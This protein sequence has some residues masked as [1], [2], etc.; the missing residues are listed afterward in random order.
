MI[1]YYEL[2]GIKNDAS[3]EE[4]KKAYRDMVKKYHPDINK[5]SDASKI[6]ISLNEAKETLLDEDKRKEYDELLNEIKYSKQYT[7]S[8]ENNTY[9]EKTKEYKENYSESY[10]TRW[11]FLMTYFKF[12]KDKVI[13]KIIKTFLVMLNY[14]FFLFIKIFALIVLFI[15]EVFEEIIDYAVG[16]IVLLGILSIFVLEQDISMGIILILI[17]VIIML[18]KEII[19]NKSL[20]IYVF[21]QNYSR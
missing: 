2:L 4:I 20:N 9:K 12:G 10:V 11:Q 21:M 19:L 15:V 1:D 13:F 14:L 16:I 18:I 6:I 8:K 3:V 5:S 17:G 7:T